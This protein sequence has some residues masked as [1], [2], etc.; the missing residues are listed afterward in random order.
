[1][2]YEAHYASGI[3]DLVLTRN[4]ESNLI[5]IIIDICPKQSI[6]KVENI[7]NLLIIV[8]NGMDKPYS[9]YASYVVAFMSKYIAKIESVTV[10]L[11]L[12]S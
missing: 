12:K 3:V 10:E 7:K 1:M 8:N 6:I 5:L 2:D 4:D 11:L 9:Q